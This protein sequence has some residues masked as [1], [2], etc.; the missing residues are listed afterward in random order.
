PYFA[1]GDSGNGVE[2]LHW[3][4][5]D[6]SVLVAQS[7]DDIETET[8]GGESLEEQEETDT[9]GSEEIEVVQE[10][11]G[12]V[13]ETAKEE[14]KGFFKI[15]E[16]NAKGFKR[17][18]VQPDN[19]QNSLGKSQWKNGKWQVMITRPLFTADKK[20]DVQFVKGKLIPYALAVWDGSNSE[21]KGQKAISSWYYLTLEMTTPKTVYVYALVAIFMAVCIQFWVVARIRRFP[22]EIPSE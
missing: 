5:Y 22:T 9:E 20:T 17:L 8:D 18:S 11:E 12:N 14:F 4:A 21:I 3:K 19:S 7:A 2:L 1:M 16:M 6:E 10:D 13:E 15:K